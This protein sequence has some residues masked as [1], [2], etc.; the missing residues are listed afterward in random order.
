MKIIDTF[1]MVVIFV[2]FLGTIATTII[3]NTTFA[4]ATDSFSNAKNYAVSYNFTLSEGNPQALSS[5]TNCTT[6]TLQASNYTDYV[7]A[8]YLQLDDNVSWT[9][10]NLCVAY[11]YDQG[12]ISGSAGVL[13]LLVTLLL[14]IG[15]IVMIKKQWGIGNRK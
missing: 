2:A 8:G 13:L 14:V 7:G 12:R 1:V 9:G 15:L 5:V 4:G 11:T 3:S 6:E 10:A